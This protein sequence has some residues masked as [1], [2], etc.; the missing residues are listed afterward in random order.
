VKILVLDENGKYVATGSVNIHIYPAGYISVIPSF[1]ST[2]EEK[3]IGNLIGETI[4]SQYSG[5]GYKFKTKF[6]ERNSIKGVLEQII[7]KL[8]ESICN[9]GRELPYPKAWHNVSMIKTDMPELLSNGLAGE[10]DV[11][12]KNV[13]LS[14]DKIDKE[15][16]LSKDN[17]NYY[18][19]SSGRNGSKVLHSFWKI[20]HI[21]EFMIFKNMVYSDF[22]PVLKE[23]L[24]WLKSLHTMEITNAKK[25][26]EQH[27][28]NTQA[29]YFCSRL[30]DIIKEPTSF[31]RALYNYIS[32]NNPGFISKPR[33]AV[34]ELIKM[35]VDEYNELTGREHPTFGFILK[36]VGKIIEIMAL[37]A[38]I[39]SKP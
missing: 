30:D 25:L 22:L 16:F 33:E 17:K 3:D 10:N 19:A 6:G 20:A 38:E 5:S 32:G 24:I 14:K 11:F 8:S 23:N 21:Y 39:L 13:C 15:F 12:Y 2:N 26:L 29:N 28:F 18:I 27:E 7:N 4:P 34:R 36:G 37:F 35:C 1:S 31:Y 9:E